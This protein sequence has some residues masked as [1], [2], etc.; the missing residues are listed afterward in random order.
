MKPPIACKQADKTVCMVVGCN[1]K[2]MYH[3]ARLTSERGYC[4]DHKEL[5]RQTSYN[6]RHIDFLADDELTTGDEL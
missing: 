3:A 2:T 1:K 6:E 4:R 5:A